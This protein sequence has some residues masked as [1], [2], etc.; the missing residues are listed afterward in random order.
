M[1]VFKSA[2]HHWGEAYG[3]VL[4]FSLPVFLFVLF[5]SFSCKNRSIRAR[6]CVWEVRATVCSHQREFHPNRA[7]HVQDQSKSMKAYLFCTISSRLFGVIHLGRK[8][9]VVGEGWTE[10]TKRGYGLLTI[11]MC[12]RRKIFTGG[13][14]SQKPSPPSSS[15]L[16]WFVQSRGNCHRWTG[17]KTIEPSG[18]D[19]TVPFLLL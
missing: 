12:A 13:R 6:V 11:A 4:P 3:L 18:T 17:L 1:R 16:S 10:G 5:T 19:S 15:L 8:L 14:H 7:P 9:C 2:A